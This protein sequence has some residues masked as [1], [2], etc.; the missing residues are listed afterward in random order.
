[1]THHGFYYN[2]TCSATEWSDFGNTGENRTG[3][4]RIVTHGFLVITLSLTR[5][6]PLQHTMCPTMCPTTRMSPPGRPSP[7]MRA[8]LSACAAGASIAELQ[9]H[10]HAE[11]APDGSP[12]DGQRDAAPTRK[13]SR[14]HAPGSR[15]SGPVAVRP[16]PLSHFE[17]FFGWCTTAQSQ[18]GRRGE[19]ADPDGSPPTMPCARC[20]RHPL[21]EA[22]LPYDT[23]SDA[24]LRAALESLR[25]PPQRG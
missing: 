19:A 15:G 8:T 16:A 1:M 5:P 18:A 6:P 17:D 9:E 25:L 2:G 12:D 10:A 3:E 22:E 7:N 4:T 23:P 21:F 11:R 13:P 14:A 20:L 24:R